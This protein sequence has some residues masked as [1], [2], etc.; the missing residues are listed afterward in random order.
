MSQRKATTTRS[1]AKKLRVAV[2]APPWLAMPVDGYGGI[3]LVVQNLVLG[4]KAQGVDVELFANGA[5]TIQGITTHSLYK[6]EQFDHIYKPYFESYPIVQ[7]HLLYAFNKIKEDGNF[8]V[9]HS[10]VPHVG[11][12]FWAMATEDKALPPVLSTFHGPPFSA[13]S[14]EIG[15]SYN[16]DDLL[17]VKEFNRFYAACISNAMTE[18]APKMVKPR[19]LPAVHNA[20]NPDE[21]PFFATKK[22]YFVTMARFSPYKGQHL[23]IKGALKHKAQLR[24]AGPVADITS[25]QRLLFELANPISSYRGNDQFRYYSDK[26]YPHVVRNRKITYSGN[27]TGK[28]K[29]KFISHAKALLFPIMW[30]EPF[31]MAV[32][33]ALACGTPVVAMNRGAMPEIITHGVTGFLANTE[34]EFIEYMG[35]VDEIDPYACRQSVVDKFSVDAMAGSYIDRYKK[36]IARAKKIA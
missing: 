34:E 24:M 25:G 30:D 6:T 17:Q 27:L 2:I 19:L 8:D 21:F 29:L 11:P 20:I 36:V 9:I 15:A 13:V 23:A 16:T 7:A 26:I 5:R 4:L 31:G 12:S 1:N 22:N 35:R 28:R 18:T 33:E 10:H 32:I 14:D 3:E